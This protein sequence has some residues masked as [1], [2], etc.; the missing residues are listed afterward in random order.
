MCGR[1]RRTTS[2]EELA[3]RYHIAIPPTTRSSDQLEHRSDTGGSDNSVQPRN[4]TTHLGRCDGAWS[5]TGPNMRKS[6]TRPST[7][8]PRRSIRHRP[9][10]KRLRKG[11][12]WFPATAFTSGKRSTGEKFRTRSA[13]RTI[14]RSYSLGC[15]RGGKIPRTENGCTLAQ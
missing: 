3:R 10:G 6:H 7:P 8:E 9:T 12:A 2:A 13:C 11:A 15:G 5:Q 14:L 4:Q 1:Y